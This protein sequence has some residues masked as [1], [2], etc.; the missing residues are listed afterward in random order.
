MR[1]EEESTPPGDAADIVK[2]LSEGDPKA[3]QFVLSLAYRYA[4]ASPD[5]TRLQRSDTA[6]FA[7]D[8]LSDAL[9]SLRNGRCRD[10][11]QL[12]NVVQESVEN[13][14]NQHRDLQHRRV[15]FDDTVMTFD[16]DSLLFSGI[17]PPEHVF[18]DEKNDSQEQ[19]LRSDVLAIDEELIRYLAAHPDDMYRLPPNRF[20][21]LVA[22]LLK[23]FGYDVQLTQ[24]GADGGVDIFATQKSGIGETLLIVD[25][26]R[27]SPSNH[28][29][30]Q[31]VRSLYGIGEQKR[32]TVAMLATTSFFTRAAQ[33]FQRDVRHRLSL[34]DYNDLVEWLRSYGHRNRH[35]PTF[36][37]G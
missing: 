26:K 17:E 32:A 22:E 11:K 27:Y 6:D 21:Q 14:L 36:G 23:N 7:Y 33:H 9:T 20:E 18:T 12:R 1:N 30:V 15:S 16:N 4:R 3:F 2:R 35:L 34:R 31:I 8:A 37:N 29:G 5:L 13:N 28:V 24:Q 19:R 25:C 10:M